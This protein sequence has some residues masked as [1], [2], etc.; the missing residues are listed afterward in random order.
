VYRAEARVAPAS[1]TETFVALKLLIDNW[2]WAGVPFYL[3]T[4]KWLL[5]RVTDIAIQ[6]KRAP[7]MPFRQTAVEHLT[8]NR[9]VLHLQPQE[10]ISLRFGAKVPGPLVR[11]GPVNMEFRHDSKHRLRAAAV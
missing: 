11:L 4:G 1:S 9:L 10:G 7:F 8:P 5:T 2:R 6:F 3:R